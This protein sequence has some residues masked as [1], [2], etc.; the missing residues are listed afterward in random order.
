VN[1]VAKTPQKKEVK[2]ERISAAIEKSVYD[3][4]LEACPNGNI[5]AGI[6]EGCN[7]L[8]SRQ[9]KVAEGKG[10]EEEVTNK[11]IYLYLEDMNQVLTEI[12]SKRAEEECDFDFNNLILNYK[13]IN[14]GKI[15]IAFI[16]Q[17]LN[18]IAE[19][20]EYLRKYKRIEYIT[21]EESFKLSISILRTLYEG[22]KVIA[23]SHFGLEGWPNEKCWRAYFDTQAMATEEGIRVERIF[24]QPTV[25]HHFP[26]TLQIL[27]MPEAKMIGYQENGEIKITE[28]VSKYVPRHVSPSNLKNIFEQGFM[29]IDLKKLIIEWQYLITLML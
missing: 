1:N 8:I 29:L 11:K 3:D 4:F 17:Q 24:C 20:I 5:S 9:G 2:N 16:K 12:Y 6:R 28:Y 7:L 27:Q 23:V 21:P 15:P 10:V 22:D 19:Q 26:K 13:D 14:A 18:K 25:K